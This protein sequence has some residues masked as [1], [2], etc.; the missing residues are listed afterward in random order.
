MNM[1]LK[2]DHESQQFITTHIY[3]SCLDWW[4]LVARLII[5]AAKEEVR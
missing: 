2:N 5:K 1:E 4:P 3:V